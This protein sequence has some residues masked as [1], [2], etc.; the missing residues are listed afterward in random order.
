MPTA[1]ARIPTRR[2]TPLP[3]RIR[4][5][6]SRIL[7]GSGVSLRVGILAVAVG[8]AIGV[9]LGALSGYAGG[10]ADLIVQ[11]FVDTMQA[12]PGLLFAILVS[13]AAGPSLEIAI[14][15]LGILSVPV[16]ARLTRGTVLVVK[17]FEY[18]EAARA[19]GCAPPR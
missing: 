8:I 12:F 11:R 19:I 17:Q 7:Y 18:V 1:T 14:T 10:V 15:A 9:P 4:D 5:I 3:Y 6:L 16:V 13:A 2:E